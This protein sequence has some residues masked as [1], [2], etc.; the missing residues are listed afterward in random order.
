LAGVAALDDAC[1][2]SR[3]PSISRAIGGFKKSRPRHIAARAGRG[4]QIA[5]REIDK[6]NAPA[7]AEAFDQIFDQFISLNNSSARGVPAV[8]K[9]NE[10][11]S[12]LIVVGCVERLIGE[13]W[14]KDAEV[15]IGARCNR[16]SHDVQQPVKFG[17]AHRALRGLS[18]EAS[19]KPFASQLIRYFKL[20]RS[21]RDGCRNINGRRH[22]S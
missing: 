18:A 7:G 15:V 11:P 12:R 16:R 2:H 1:S 17:L 8:R 22:A 9:R 10:R 5:L 3:D 19:Q 20:Y 4:P 6:Q 14:H 13:F 21:R